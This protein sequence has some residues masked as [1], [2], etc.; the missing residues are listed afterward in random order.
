VD[1]I[2]WSDAVLRTLVD[3]ARET[4]GGHTMGV[5]ETQLGARLFGDT[6]TS[7]SYHGSTQREAMFDALLSLE[8]IGAVEGARKMWCTITRGGRGHAAD[9]LP[10]WQQVCAETFDPEEEQLLRLINR[11]SPEPMNDHVRLR[12]IKYDAAVAELGWPNGRQKVHE[13]A[14]T[15]GDAG[16]IQ[17]G[18]F[19]MVATYKGLAWETRRAFTLQAALID[20]LVAD[21]ETTSVDHK[22][23][24]ELGSNDQKAE[25]VKDVIA[26]ANTLV[27]GRRWMVIGFND[28]TR[29]YH[30]PPNP[31]ITED[32]LI[33]IIQQYVTPF[34]NISYLAVEHR[35][36][37]VGLL[38]VLPER[39]MLPYK[40]SKGL[41]GAKRKI[42]PGDLWV[43]HGSHSAKPD[44][45]ELDALREEAMRARK[46]RS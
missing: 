20:Q 28:K 13:W 43:R 25:L 36:G 12:E 17:S 7:G 27:S 21:W 37:L 31:G 23:E 30:N 1:F 3:L 11:L 18:A 35:Q 5:H 15:L 40:V 4:D 29:A 10:Y 19:D 33:D 45:E 38:E 9:P 16:F 14:K 32:R 41:K 34:P 22:Q 2:E 42:E 44:Q 26:L 39:S 24:L 6:A 8:T 46:A